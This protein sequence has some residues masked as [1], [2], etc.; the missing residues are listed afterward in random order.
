[1]PS[2]RELIQLTPAEIAGFLETSKTIILVS[3]GRDGFPHPMPMWFHADAEGVVHCTTF[4]RSQKV[5]NLERDPK[6]TL[7]VERGEEYAQLKGLLIYAHAE[8]V[9]DTAAVVDTLVRINTRGVDATPEHIEQLTAAV[10]GTAAKRVLLR[11]RPERYVS[12]DH[13]K[14]GGRY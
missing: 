12:W 10:R 1:M 6:T 5:A 8:I 4:A 9:A 14:L 3:N 13:A 11:F 2:R 7:L